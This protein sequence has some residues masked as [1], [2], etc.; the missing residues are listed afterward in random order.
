MLATVRW[1]KILRPVSVQHYFSGAVTVVVVVVVGSILAAVVFV[2]TATLWTI[3][4]P[5]WRERGSGQGRREDGLM[6]PWSGTAWSPGW[7]G[8]NLAF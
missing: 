7:R 4:R 8:D 1:M 6:G 2:W 3:S 5:W